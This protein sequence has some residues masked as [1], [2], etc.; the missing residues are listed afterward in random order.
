MNG[1]EEDLEVLAMALMYEKERAGNI[2]HQRLVLQQDPRND[3]RR[4]ADRAIVVIREACDYYD[5]VVAEIERVERARAAAL[6][7]EP[8]RRHETA[9]E[10]SRV[11][12]VDAAVVGR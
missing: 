12:R 7:A 1:A 10:R 9:E 3:P 6:N 4:E 11:L 2:L 8:V 5:R